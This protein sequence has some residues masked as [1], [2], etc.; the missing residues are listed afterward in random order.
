LFHA[1]NRN[2][3]K[4]IIDQN[5][6]VS[7][8]EPSVYFSTHSTGTG[9]GDHTVAANIDPKLLNID[10]EFPNGR[11][12]YRIDKPTVSVSGAQ[13]VSS[14]HL[15]PSQGIRAFHGSPYDFDKFDLSKIGTGEG[16]QAYGHG[17][18]FAENPTV[19]QE[20]KGRLST[21]ANVN[22]S[23]E[24]KTALYYL[25]QNNFDKIAARADL[26]NRIRQKLPDTHPQIQAINSYDPGK[27]YEVNIN[28]DP[29]HFLDWDKPLSEQHPKVQEALSG[30]LPKGKLNPD[31]LDMGGGATIVDN[32]NG[33]VKPGSAAPWI[34]KSGNSLFDLSQKDVDRMLSEGQA[35]ESAY[36]RLT[37]SLGSQTAATQT[38]HE[39][40]IP[41]IKYLDQGSRGSGEGTRNFVVFNDQLVDIIKKYGLAGLVAGGAAHFKTQPVDNNPFE[42]T[43]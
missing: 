4:S 41:G 16:A 42:G 37:S 40:G 38:L 15:A 29:E 21:L 1:T 27:M 20:Y 39:A 5:K 36:T 32:R 11:V 19:A 10:D 30:I 25:Q 6:I 22:D 3:A 24:A 26:E 31:G 33:K 43:Q 14:P 8:G 17:L 34:L 7:G 2:A 13:L 18:Y 23:P 9:Y 28:A 12:D 35:G